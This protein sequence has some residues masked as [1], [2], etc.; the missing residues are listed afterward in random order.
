MEKLDCRSCLEEEIIELCLENDIKKFR[1]NQ[2]FQWVQQ[3]GAPNWEEMKN[4]SKADKEKLSSIFFLASLEIIRE[5]RS[6]DGTRKFLFRLSDGL[7]VETVL[8]DYEN[9]FSRDRQTVCLSTQVGCPVGCSFCATGLAGFQRN[10]TAGEITGQVLEVV[11]RLRLEDPEFKVT[12]IVFMGMGEPFLN[13]EA[14]LKSI[15]ILNSENGQNI[16]MRRMTISTSGVVPRIIQLAK[17][18]PQVGL[19]ISLHS[20]KDEIRDHLVPMNRRY[21][22]AKLIQACKNYTSAT[23]RR[24][25]FE[26]ALSD[27]NTNKEEAEGLIRL[28]QGLMAHV[29]LIP[30]NP[31]VGSRVK[32]PPKD[33]IIMFKKTLEA[34]RIQVSVREEKGVDIDAACG[35]LR[36]RMECEEY[37]SVNQS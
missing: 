1:A 25:S 24:I 17:D 6:A 4:I 26:V 13:Y 22:L 30:V 18:N 15:K 11:R 37:E 19:A 33:K 34:A 32:R 12:N 5:Q 35:Q 8:M 3:K 28:L 27:Q 2:V 14:V 23:N 21:P 20:S 36:Q 9:T 7:S 29:N 16:G 31:V 10:L